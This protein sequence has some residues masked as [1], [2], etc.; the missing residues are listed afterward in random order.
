MRIAKLHTIFL[1][2]ASILCSCATEKPVIN[3]VCELQSDGAYMLKWETFP[4]LTGMVKIYASGQP[5][6]FNLSSPIAT[7]NITN[8]FSKVLPIP[9][10]RTYF[11]LIFNGKDSVVTANRVVPFQRI[12]NFRDLGGYANNHNKIVRWGKIYRSGS[13]AAASEQDLD[14]LSKM[15]IQTI[16]DLRSESEIRAFPNKLQASYVY[17]LP[18][19]G[20]RYDTFLEQSI[21]TKM[22]R[23]DV[24][25]YDRNVNTFLMEN[26]ADYFEKLFQVLLNE[27]N[28]PIVMVGS[29][30]K[31]R[32]ACAVSLIFEALEM[33]EVTILNDFLLSNDLLNFR[34]IVQNADEFTP[35]IQETMT[36]LLRVHEETFRYTRTV[37]NEN[38]GSLNNYLEKELKVTPNDREHLKMILLYP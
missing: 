5:D 31:D 25:E 33:D 20:N 4:P 34:S 35:A 21:L 13:L 16:I 32:V 15:H 26:N 11:Q 7:E 22:T 23:A 2:L 27:A 37:M 3:A 6:F 1:F 18:L 8:G 10:A 29:L 17:N 9:A 12:V 28:Y 38:Y 36:A 30:G 14:D 24:L 19:R